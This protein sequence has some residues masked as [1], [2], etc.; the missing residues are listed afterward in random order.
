[1]AHLVPSRRVP[2][3][4]VPSCRVPSRRVSL[5][6]AKSFFAVLAGIEQLYGEL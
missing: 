2:S 1:M 5:R 6:F 3:R 4:R